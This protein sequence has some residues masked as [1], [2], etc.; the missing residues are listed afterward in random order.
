MRTLLCIIFF[1]LD[2]K[3]KCFFLIELNGMKKKKSIEQQ[4]VYL[5]NFCRFLFFFIIQRQ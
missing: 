4:N 2:Q 1:L 3:Y 5:Q